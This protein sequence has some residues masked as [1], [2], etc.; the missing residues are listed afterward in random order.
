MKTLKYTAYI[1]HILFIL[2]TVGGWRWYPCT[3]ILLP[4]VGLSWEINDN[5]CVFTE[6]EQYYFGESL[7]PGRINRVTRIAVWLNLAWRSYILHARFEILPM[8]AAC[9]CGGYLFAKVT[10]LS[11]MDA[12]SSGIL[13]YGLRVLWLSR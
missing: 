7:V 8:M 6:I 10:Q 1:F 12:G 3:S 4:I 5:Q 9:T 13:E 11:S 2:I